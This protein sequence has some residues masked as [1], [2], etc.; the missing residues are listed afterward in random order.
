MDQRRQDMGRI[1]PLPSPGQK[2]PEEDSLDSNRRQRWSLL[3]EGI[4]EEGG[5]NQMVTQ[6][7]R[8]EVHTDV[9][10]LDLILDKVILPYLKEHED[11]EDKVQ[12]RVQDL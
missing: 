3:R 12:L 9:A 7:K 10:T 6:S 2:T 1:V 5:R 8:T 4:Q 11:E